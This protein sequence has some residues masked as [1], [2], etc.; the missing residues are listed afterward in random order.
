MLKSQ[1]EG[2]KQRTE[3]DA[4]KPK[5]E[6]RKQKWDGQALNLV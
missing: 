4:E 1:P 5:A 3:G 2:R 6:S